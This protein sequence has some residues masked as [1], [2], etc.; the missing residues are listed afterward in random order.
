M[1][2][3]AHGLSFQSIT[4][5]MEDAKEIS[6]EFSVDIMFMWLKITLLLSY[7]SLNFTL[8]RFQKCAVFLTV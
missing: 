2:H 4:S 3:S 1:T 5:S 8:V 6:D 7:E